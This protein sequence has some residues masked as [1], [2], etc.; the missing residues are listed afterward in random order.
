ML[1]F[2]D[3]QGDEAYLDLTVGCG[4]HA[5]AVAEKLGPGGQIVGIDHDLEALEIAR[6][7]LEE[8]GPVLLRGSFGELRSLRPSLPVPAFD[9][10]LADLGVSSLQLDEGRRGFSFRR[11]GPLDMRMN[12]E[13]GMSAQEWVATTSV[14]EMAQV[15]REFGEDRLARKIAEEID[16]VR[17]TRPIETT[18]ELADIVRSVV[19]KK[20]DDTID[21]ATRTFQAIRIAVN[22]EMR[23]LDQ[24]LAHFE[25]WLRPG[26]R[27]AIIAYHS[28]EDRR[29]KEAFRLRGKEGEFEVL[30]A[31]PVR[32]TESEIAANPRA[33]SARL[34]VLRRRGGRFA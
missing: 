21:P 11:D 7:A 24:L 1:H 31:K 10:V 33:R 9:L 14:T 15:I 5:R 2:L 17:R 20:R 8:R 30:T 29:V 13:R 25:S 34:R 6:A 19:P 23:A 26:G 12:S 3:P 32:P 28:L 18:G 22:E 16:R 4:G 27:F